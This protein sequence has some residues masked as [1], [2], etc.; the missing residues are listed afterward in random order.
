MRTGL[1]KDSFTITEI[2][3]C[4]RLRKTQ[5]LGVQKLFPVE[6][7][8]LN[9]K[10]GGGPKENT[11]CVLLYCK[12]GPNW[13]ALLKTFF[14]KTICQDTLNNLVNLSSISYQYMYMVLII[15]ADFDIARAVFIN[16]A[17]KSISCIVLVVWFYFM[18]VSI[19]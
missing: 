8:H 7:Q 9:L 12:I 11:Y 16:R 3:L 17:R 5:K 1:L 2:H 6:G 18:Y 19:I 10:V 4:H 13:T 15:L 14:D